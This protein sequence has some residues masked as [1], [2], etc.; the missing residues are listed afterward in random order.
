MSRKVQRGTSS[1]GSATGRPSHGQEECGSGG[2]IVDP[3]D[4]TTEKENFEDEKLM[5]PCMVRM[6][7]ER[8]GQ[9]HEAC[10]ARFKRLSTPYGQEFAAGRTASLGG[11]GAPTGSPRA[12]Q[13]V[14]DSGS[15]QVNVVEIT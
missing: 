6:R 1:S 9:M 11:N 8:I 3:V 7:T 2:E 14:C 15:V 4:E 10:F 13:D 12:L 5:F